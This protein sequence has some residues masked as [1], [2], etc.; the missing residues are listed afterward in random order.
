MRIMSEQPGAVLRLEGRLDVTTVADVRLALHDAV[1]HGE[2]DL[3]INLGGV[4]LID[5]TGLGVLVGAHRRAERCGRRLVLH[6][7]P[8]RVLRLLTVT[9]LS[10]ILAVDVAIDQAPAAAL[11]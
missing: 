8:P 3:V 1:D 2:G 7:V 11:A 6:A 10:R 4:E 5:A 9:K